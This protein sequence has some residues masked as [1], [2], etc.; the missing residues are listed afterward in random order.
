MDAFNQA[1]T[2]VTSKVDFSR[3]GSVDEPVQDLLQTLNLH[4]DLFSLSSCS[5]RIIILREGAV[6]TGKVELKTIRNIFKK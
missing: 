1:K 6:N 2:S 4:P 5:G 3:K